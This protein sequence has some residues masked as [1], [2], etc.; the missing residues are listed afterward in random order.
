[1]PGATADGIR[2]TAAQVIDL[3]RAVVIVTTPTQATQPGG[4]K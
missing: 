4:G 1:V 3:A 2:A